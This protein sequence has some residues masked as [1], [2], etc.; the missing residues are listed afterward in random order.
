MVFWTSTKNG[1]A[2][3]HQIPR[4]GR[5]SGLYQ[6]NLL[7]KS[8]R[9]S[10]RLERWWSPFSGIQMRRRGNCHRALLCRIFE[11]IR[12]RLAEKATPFYEEKSPLPLWSSIVSHLRRRHDQIGRSKVW[13]A[14][15]ST[16]FSRSGTISF[17]F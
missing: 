16:E 8:Q 4:D 2:V 3:T 13:T 12:L 6:A 9:L 7:R 1:S 14:V 17:C 5:N 11:L 15:P 10:Y